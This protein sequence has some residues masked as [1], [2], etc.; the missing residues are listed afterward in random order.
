MDTTDDLTAGIFCLS[1]CSAV[2]MLAGW[3]DGEEL[4]CVQV[5]VFKVFESQHNSQIK[6][7]VMLESMSYGNMNLLLI[8][9]PG[10]IDYCTRRCL[11][12]Y[13]I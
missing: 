5:S 9:D 11:H 1:M 7:R 10:I 3:M 2:E 4:D 8:A 6:F 12:H 13:P